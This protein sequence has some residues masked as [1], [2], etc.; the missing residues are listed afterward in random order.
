[1]RMKHGRLLLLAAVL[2]ATSPAVA[3]GQ[4]Q[5][6]VST[7]VEAL[8]VVQGDA[9]L[10][11]GVTFSANRAFTRFSAISRGETGTSYG[12]ALG[13]GR[14]DYDFGEDFA[15]WNKTRFIRLSA[16][17][18]FQA[19]E[20]GSVFISP[21]VR[22]DY[23][24]NASASDGY[25]YG[26]LGGIAWR[27]NENLT[28]GP[29]FGAFSEL[30]EGGM[31]VFPALLVDWNINARWNLNTGSGLGASE[32]P[33]LTLSYRISDAS[34]LS[35]SGRS[36]NIRF[37][38]DDE[39]LAPGGVGED[40]ALPLVVSYLYEPNPATSLSVFAGAEFNGELTLRDSQGRRIDRQ[41][42]D[43][44]PLLGFAVRLRF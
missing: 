43:T 34:R 6:K 25:T 38:L 41:S 17:V 7:S 2:G 33:G 22:W 20:T 39:G 18:R 29:A 14:Y 21:Q 11:N 44:A 27:F 13:L 35:L 9:D 4:Q 40:S 1:M 12:L 26:V 31:N 5:S 15:P 19:G 24:E 37:R 16:P 42:Y 3:Q 30:E 36:E 10:D 23:D 32:G 8:G 28:I